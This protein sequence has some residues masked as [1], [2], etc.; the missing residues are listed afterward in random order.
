MVHASTCMRSSTTTHDGSRRILSWT[1]E[2]RLGSGA[3]CRVSR[4]AARHVVDISG[5]PTVVVD[6]GSE[7]VNREVDDLLESLDLTRVMAQI[8]VTF[9]NSTIE[10][11]WR[12]LKHAWIY[13]HTLDNMGSV[14]RLIQF[15]VTAHN[16]VMP[17]AA[18]EGQTPDEM[19]FGTRD[20]VIVELAALRR[21][22][23]E[24]RMKTNR[25]ARCGV[26]DGESDS[27]VLQVQRL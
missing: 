6:S 8:E 24:D 14:R 3:T 11:F 5:E 17:H 21:E 19:F 4:E 7:N 16:E 2:E 1:L 15:Y 18:F 9:S 23:R 13:L 10:A 25:F 12:S 26:C 22:A 20:G 27:A